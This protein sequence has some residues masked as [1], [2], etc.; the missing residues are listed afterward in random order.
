MPSQMAARIA[1]GA[2]KVSNAESARLE[3]ERVASFTFSPGPGYA[4]V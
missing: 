3:K 4:E 1:V 2:I